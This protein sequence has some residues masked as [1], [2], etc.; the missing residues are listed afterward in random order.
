MRL[1]SYGL[2]IG[3]AILLT[4]EVAKRSKIKKISDLEIERTAWHVVVGGILGARTYHLLDQL[5][6]YLQNPERILAVWQGGLGIW[7]GIGGG[8][9]T[10]WILK[11]I[12][13]ISNLVNTLDLAGLVLPLAQSI[14]RWGNFFNRELW[15]KNGEPIFL[16]ESILSVFLFIVLWKWQDKFKPGQLFGAYL[17]GYG[18]IRLFLELWRAPVDQW[19]L[20]S[21]PMFL[22]FP[23]V[24]ILIGQLIT[25]RRRF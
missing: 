16:Y 21:T 17:S 10:I 5:Q 11:K 3:L 19:W 25:W 9:L 22:L 2:V 23:I 20:G 6:Y 7:G 8:L 12:N 13:K 1:N 18:G 14:G 15:G 4:I 24:S